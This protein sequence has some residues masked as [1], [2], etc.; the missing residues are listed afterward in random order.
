MVPHFARYLVGPDFKKLVPASTIL[1]GITTLLIYDVC[2]IIA[3]TGRFNL[4]TGV[5]YSALSLFFMLFYRRQ[6]HADWA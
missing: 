4:Y 3:E 2:Y 1:G 6:R 5:V